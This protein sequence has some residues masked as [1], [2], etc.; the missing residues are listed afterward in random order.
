MAIKRAQSRFAVSE[1]DVQ[2]QI[3]GWMTLKRIFFYRQNT[4]GMKKGK[5]F[6]RF[7][8]KGAPDIVAVLKG[9]YVGIEVK[10]PGG[11]QTLDQAAFETMLVMAGGKYILASCLKDVIACFDERK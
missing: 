2:G 8:V 10:R 3:M 5:H 6:V 11:C 9:Q 7:G 4:G 1:H